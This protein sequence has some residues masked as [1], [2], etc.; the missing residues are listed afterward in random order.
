MNRAGAVLVLTMA[1]AG[2]ALAG[3]V[4]AQTAQQN[5]A[6]VSIDSLLGGQVQP[7]EPP[8]RPPPPPP[9]QPG[10]TTP[11]FLHETHRSPDGPPTVE[12]AAYDSRLKS[13]AAAARGFQGPMEGAWSLSSGGRDLY[14]L[15]LIDREGWIDGAW[16]DP[17][18]AG[19]V[20]ASGLISD[21]RRG[22]DLTLRF[23]TDAVA[24]LRSDAGGWRG[25]LT[26]RGQ[27]Q[28]VTL[29]RRTP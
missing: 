20:D 7:V 27:A 29:V 14:L 17:R 12:A 13:S 15:Q 22:G 21:V 25:E 11:V 5:P 26:E 19:G 23:S 1:L 6:P 4:H 28:P 3:H 18:R 8:P 2:M 9:A 16:R 10:L 24:V